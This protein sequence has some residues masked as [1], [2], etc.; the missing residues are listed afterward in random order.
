MQQSG[1]PSRMLSVGEAADFLRIQDRPARS[2]LNRGLGRVCGSAPSTYYIG[3]KLSTL[4][5]VP[6]LAAGEAAGSA[7][8]HGETD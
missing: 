1:A 3:K 5:P 8:R 4:T 6:G 2:V 7:A